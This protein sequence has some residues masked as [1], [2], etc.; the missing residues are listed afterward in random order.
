M[1]IP[2]RMSRSLRGN[3]DRNRTWL[4]LNEALLVVPYVGTWI[5]IGMMCPAND[6]VAVVPYVGTWIEIS[7]LSSI[8]MQ[9]NVVPYVGTWIEI[10]VVWASQSASGGRSLRGNVDRN[11]NFSCSSISW[12]SRSLRGNVDRNMKMGESKSWPSQSFPTWERG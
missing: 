11:C 1:L 2:I 10:V 7:H 4:S 6:T 9:D 12:W 8:S 5:E 3:V